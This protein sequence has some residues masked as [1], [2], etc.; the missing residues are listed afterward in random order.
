MFYPPGWPV[1]QESRVRWDNLRLTTD[2]QPPGMSLPLFEQGAVERTFDTPEFRG[3]TFY[4]VRARSIINRVPEASRVT[5]RWTINPYRGCSHA[6]VY[7]LEGHTPILMADGRTKPLAEVETG[8]AVYGTIREG[9]YRRLT[10]ARVLAHWSTVNPAYRISLEDGTELIASG[11]HRFLTDRGWKHVTGR[12]Q[13]ALRRPHLTV[14][15]KLM[16]SGRFASAPRDTPDYRR[17][18][19]CGMIRGDGHLGSYTYPRPGRVRCDVHR[20]RLALV[21]L[22]ALRRSRSYL[23]DAGVATTEFVF[24]EAIGQRKQ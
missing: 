13:G 22:E 3:I 19:L 12:E 14:N 17:G 16:G 18:Y 15:N 20:F 21:D 9:V 7:C 10:V 11:D 1:L 4:E 2:Q 24:Q 23:M 8:E 5:F 6:C